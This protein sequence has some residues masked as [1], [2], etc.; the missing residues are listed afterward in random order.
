MIHIINAVMT[1][2]KSMVTDKKNAFDGIN[3]MQD[4]WMNYNPSN[5]H[6]IEISE[7]EEKENGTEEILEKTMT[8]NSSKIKESKYKLKRLRKKQTT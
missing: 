1:E 6:V 8:G 7:G 4:L 2:I 5:I 3:G